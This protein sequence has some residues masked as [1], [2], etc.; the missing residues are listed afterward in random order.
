MISSMS[1]QA[2]AAVSGAI[3][4]ITEC[5][6]VQIVGGDPGSLGF[7]LPEIELQGTQ[8]VTIHQLP[9][10]HPEIIAPPDHEMDF[11]ATRVR[12]KLMARVHTNTPPPSTSS[13][14][15]V[16]K[17]LFISISTASEYF[18]GHSIRCRRREGVRDLSW[19]RWFCLVSRPGSIGSI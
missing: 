3:S 10:T 8:L 14:T 13:V 15:P 5:S 2:L 4:T 11:F 7:G 6:S 18:A 12:L 16:M 19:T 17:L 9:P 1:N